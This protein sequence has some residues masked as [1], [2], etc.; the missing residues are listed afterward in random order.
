MQNKCVKFILFEHIEFNLNSISDL[1]EE[2]FR[3]LFTFMTTEQLSELKKHHDS[4]GHTTPHT[5]KA[6]QSANQGPGDDEYDDLTEEEKQQR[7]GIPIT[8]TPNSPDFNK[9][10]IKRHSYTLKRLFI[11]I[12]NA[13][14]LLCKNVS[15][16]HIQSITYVTAE[17]LNHIY[18]AINNILDSYGDFTDGLGTFVDCVDVVKR[19]EKFKFAQKTYIDTHDKHRLQGKYKNNPITH[20]TDYTRYSISLSV[21]IKCVQIKYVK[22]QYYSMRH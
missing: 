10:L 11:L 21:M 9:K 8:W 22:I 3:E 4:N 20:F 19:M 2:V 17:N 7:D 13:R 1:F 15:Y 16:Y 18:L 12:L 6:D 5:A 14:D